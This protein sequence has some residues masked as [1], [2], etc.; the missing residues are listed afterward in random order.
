[1]ESCSSDENQDIQVM[2]NKQYTH[3]IK[4]TGFGDYCLTGHSGDKAENRVVY[5]EP[6]YRQKQHWDIIK[7]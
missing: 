1:M 7:L 4:F 2:F 5:G 3:N 6:C